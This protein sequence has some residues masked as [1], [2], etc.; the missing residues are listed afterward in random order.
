MR[1]RI[2]K[3]LEYFGIILNK[4]LNNK[5]VSD[6]KKIS[7]FFSPVKVLVVCTDEMNQIAK[8]TLKFFEIK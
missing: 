3:N 1:D 6:D 5:T 7:S 2:C 4:K 8:E